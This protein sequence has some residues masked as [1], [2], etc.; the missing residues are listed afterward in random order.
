MWREVRRHTRLLV[1]AVEVGLPNPPGP[2]AACVSARLS[3][4]R[5]PPPSNPTYTL[6]HAIPLSPPPT[7]S[8]TPF[9]PERMDI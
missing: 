6:P 3:L 5:N 4:S 8:P 1:E 9:R 7:P 2:A